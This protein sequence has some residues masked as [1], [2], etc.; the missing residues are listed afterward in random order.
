[1]F[2]E[3]PEAKK[4]LKDMIKYCLSIEAYA[5]RYEKEK[6]EIPL[7]VR[8][9]LAELFESYLEKLPKDV[10]E[11]YALGIYGIPGIIP[12]KEIPRLIREDVD[13]A[14]IIIRLFAYYAHKRGVE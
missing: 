10:R 2:I 5:E 6:V 14:N 12:L 4:K 1:M 11:N 13:F 7:E 3:P 8:I 9:R